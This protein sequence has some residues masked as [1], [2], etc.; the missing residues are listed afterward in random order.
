MEFL[1][2]TTANGEIVISVTK[3]EYNIL[4]QLVNSKEARVSPAIMEQKRKTMS[5]KM[6]R[7]GTLLVKN[8]VTG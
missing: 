1:D 5:K 3:D 2:N 6:K 8:A 7:P 4:W